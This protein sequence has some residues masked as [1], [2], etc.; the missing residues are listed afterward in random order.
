MAQRACRAAPRRGPRWRHAVGRH[1]AEQARGIAGRADGRAQIHH[2]LRVG[3][4]ACVRAGA[5]RLPPTAPPGSRRWKDRRRCPRG[6]REHAA[7]VAVED[8][9]PLAARER[10]DRGRGRAPDARAGR[11]VRRSASGTA[12][13][14]RATTSRAA[15]MQVAS[16]RVV[17]EPAPEREHVVH[18]GGGERGDRRKAREEALVVRQHRR[19]LRLLQH[20]LREPDAIGVARALPGQAMAAVRPLPADDAGGEWAGSLPGGHPGRRS[21]TRGPD[22]RV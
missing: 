19:D 3:L 2:A 5:P 4:D 6:A 12:P 7:H 13:P 20:D 14:N 18:V 1:R 21:G 22:A 11:R 16:A 10:G 15:R 9:A 8:R 17:A